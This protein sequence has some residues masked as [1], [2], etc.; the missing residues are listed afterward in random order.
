MAQK[1]QI[2]AGAR[3]YI[4]TAAAPETI[5]RSNSAVNR[6][7]FVKAINMNLTQ[8]TD[9]VTV[10]S[11]DLDDFAERFI[12]ALSNTT[13]TM[14]SLW[15]APTGSYLLA[16]NAIRLGNNHSQ[17]RSKV[18]AILDPFGSVTGNLSFSWTFMIT[19]LPLVGDLGKALGGQVGFQVDGPVALGA[20]P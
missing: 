13:G 14:D 9:N 10:L 19:Q 5:V 11:A 8:A 20:V 4:A 15:D 3:I 12:A 6:T 18:N 16:L 1:F 17:G 2:A 7:D